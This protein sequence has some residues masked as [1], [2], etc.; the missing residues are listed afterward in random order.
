MIIATFRW[1]VGPIVGFYLLSY[2]HSH[3]EWLR[4]FHDVR[5]IL[6]I[7]ATAQARPQSGWLGGWVDVC[8]A[9][10]THLPMAVLHRLDDFPLYIATFR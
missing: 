8:L 6:V 4:R 9:N 10:M 7:I 1:L 3:R 5:G 2:Y